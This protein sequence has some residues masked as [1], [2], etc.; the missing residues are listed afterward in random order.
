[1]ER[2]QKLEEA[3]HELQ[4][5]NVMLEKLALTDPLTSLPNRRAIDRLVETELRRRGRYPSWLTFGVVDADRFK[6]INCRYLLTGGDQVLID[7]ARALSASVRTVDTIG[8]VGGEEFVV[9]APET[10]FEGALVLAERIRSSVAEYRF[11][12]KQEAI[13]VTVSGGFVVVEP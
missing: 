1:L 10:T 2:T 7:L 12:Y 5:K 6:D 8:R 11:S 13:S 3:N 9:V 4:Q